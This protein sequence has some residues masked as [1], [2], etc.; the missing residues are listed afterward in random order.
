MGDSGPAYQIGTLFGC[1]DDLHPG[2]ILQVVYTRDYLVTWSANLYGIGPG[3]QVYDS[4]LGE[5]PTSHGNTVDDE[6]YF[7]S[8]DGRSV[9]EDHLDFRGHAT[10]MRPGF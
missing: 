4:F 2:G 5:F 1:A 3:S 9:G 7:S 6:H 10:S 8:S